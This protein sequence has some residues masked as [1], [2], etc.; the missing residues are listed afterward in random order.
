VGAYH[1]AI[2]RASGDPTE[3]VAL[4]LR[5]GRV[6]TDETG[7]IEKALEQFRAVHDADPEN[8][9]ALAALERLYRQ[10]SNHTELLAIYE[11][12]REL[13]SDPDAR[14]A[15]LASIA[16]L[17]VVELANPRAGID[18][19]RALLEESPQDPAALAALDD[20]Y[21]GLEDWE[22]Y[23]EILRARLELDNPEERIVDLKYRL[24]SVLEKHLGDPAAALTNYREILFIDPANEPARLAL[25]AL[26]ENPELRAETAAILQEI[27]EGR[28]DWA[29][30]I[31]TLEI[32][33]A[34][35]EDR[36]VALLRKVARVAAENLEDLPRAVEAQARALRTDPSDAE[37]LGELEV[38][39]EQANA[40][41]ELE[42]ILSEIA[43][44]L[45]DP[46]L[47]RAY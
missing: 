39:A 19:Y 33:A 21:R 28:G 8:V 16:E 27:Y 17:H 12:K 43:E 7:Q 37:T 15:I 38:L 47:A 5:L 30:L 11:K 14:R 18:T 13:A 44:G 34:A 3:E 46:A 26:L 2:E 6:L 45:S 10:T 32:L 24:G 9:D 41:D 20:L 22:N 1:R 4:R 40:W 31:G 23:A 25:E 36:R 29:K 35:E 42:K